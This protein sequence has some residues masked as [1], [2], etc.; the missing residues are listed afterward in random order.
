[1]IDIN[2]SED[3]VIVQMVSDYKQYEISDFIIK[4]LNKLD[5]DAFEKSLMFRLLRREK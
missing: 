4:L 2:V 5:S 1:M 3:A